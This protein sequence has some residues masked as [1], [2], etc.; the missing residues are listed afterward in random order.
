[1][2]LSFYDTIHVKFVSYRYFDS[3]SKNYSDV[4]KYLVNTHNFRCKIQQRSLDLR[5]ILTLVTVHH[6]F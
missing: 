1:M 3:D 5:S 4:N 2:I 6:Y